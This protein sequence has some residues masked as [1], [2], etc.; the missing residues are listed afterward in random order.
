MLIFLKLCLAHLVADFLLQFDELFKLKLR[1]VWGHIFHAGFHALVSL[2]LLIPYW[3]DPFIW[4]FVI[5]T[6]AIHFFQDRLKYR[7]MGNQR[8]FFLI[9]IA[10]QIFHV[11]FLATI[12]LFPISAEVRGFGCCP[13]GAAPLAAALGKGCP[14]LN[15]LYTDNHWTLAAIVFLTATFAGSF[16]LYAFR[17]SYLPGKRPD[18]LISTFEIF[19]A[20]AERSVMTGIFLFAPSPVFFAAA[21]LA[22]L[23]RLPFP[24]VRNFPDFILSLVWAAATGLIFRPYL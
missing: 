14:V 11:L 9:F 15:A 13:T 20:L 17:K 22:G 16:T 18:Q 23:S 6:S 7:F 1:S 3:G 21:P 5:A 24:Q 2:L 19:H 8:F 10:D 12:F 4:I